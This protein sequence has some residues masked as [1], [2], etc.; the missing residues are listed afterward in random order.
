MANGRA[1]RTIGKIK[2]AIEKIVV[3][4][5]GDRGE[6]LPQLLYVYHRR[7]RGPTLP[8][9]HMMYGFSPR[10]LA[11]DA[12]ELLA[13]ADPHHRLLEIFGE[14]AVCVAAAA[15]S[16][17]PRKSEEKEK[18]FNVGDKVL[19]AHSQAFNKTRK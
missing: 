5:R 17:E 4:I 3:I 10:M 14:S 15:N 18:K 2:Y 6:V 16:G 8:T 7:D 1:E 13:D 19:V 12:V 9:F 11:S